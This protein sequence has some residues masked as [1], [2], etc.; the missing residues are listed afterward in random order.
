VVESEDRTK[1]YEEFYIYL[2]G[3]IPMFKGFKPSDEDYGF[4]DTIVDSSID[5]HFL[6]SKILK[7]AEAIIAKRKKCRFGNLFVGI[8]EMSENFKA[9]YPV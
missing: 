3:M 1:A 7:N 4:I 8:K 6:A 9:K 2:Q 5:T